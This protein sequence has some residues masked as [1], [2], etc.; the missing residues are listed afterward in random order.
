MPQELNK[1][2][3]SF[4]RLITRILRGLYESGKFDQSDA[5]MYAGI[6][7]PQVSRILS[8]QE[9]ITLD[10]LE[11]FCMAADVYM[12]DVINLANDER[13][14]GTREAVKV[15]G[16]PIAE[17]PLSS[18]ELFELRRSE[19]EASQRYYKEALGL[20]I[21]TVT[22]IITDETTSRVLWRVIDCATYCG[23]SSRTWTNYRAN[24]RAPQPV[25]HLDGRTPLWDAEEVKAWHAG[26]PGAPI[27]SSQ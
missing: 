25:A 14:F 10:Q 4:G 22:P 21:K 16:W 15:Q 3:G 18:K 7:A 20:E 9:S 23:I 1:G 27:R 11:G 2:P 8:F 5:A 24:G 13:V 6:P 12:I 19:A 26:R 17:D